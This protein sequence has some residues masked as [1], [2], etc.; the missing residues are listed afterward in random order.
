M[1]ISSL[2]TFNLTSL[3]FSSLV[4]SFGVFL[5]YS[6]IS[7]VFLLQS[8]SLLRS[9]SWDGSISIF[10]SS[11]DIVNLPV[12]GPIY[13]PFQY[14]LPLR[15]SILKDFSLTLVAHGVFQVSLFSFW[16]HLFVYSILLPGWFLL[17]AAYLI[18]DI[19]FKIFCPDAI[20]FSQI[21]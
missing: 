7:F 4:C 17:V 2:E 13:L 16:F 9:F 11:Q 19:F 21:C 1:V 18:S 14:L 10:I 5:L 3:P 12:F 8:L 15:A 6:N 20:L